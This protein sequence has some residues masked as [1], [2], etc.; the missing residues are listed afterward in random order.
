MRD[1]PEGAWVLRGDRGLT[2]SAVLPEGNRIVAGRWWP[3]DY[4]GPPLISLDVDAA[5]ALGLKVGDRMTVA[6]LGRPIEARIASLRR[7]DWR[8]YGFNFAIIFSPGVLERAPFTLMATVAPA[9]KR[10]DDDVRAREGHELFREPDSRIAS[11]DEHGSP[12]TGVDSEDAPERAEAGERSGERN[13]RDEREPRPRRENEAEEQDS[14]EQAKHALAGTDVGHDFLLR[15]AKQRPCRRIPDARTQRSHRTV[16]AI[17]S[18]RAIRSA[19]DPQRRCSCESWSSEA[20][21][22]A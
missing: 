6:V 19:R 2:F 21:R 13:D 17:G 8:S 9:W 1:I 20:W 10:D 16:T 18:G 12:A 3:A 4:R 15:K 5:K 22:R 14:D 11:V 7:I